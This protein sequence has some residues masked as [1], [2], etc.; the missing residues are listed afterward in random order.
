MGSGFYEI[1]FTEKAIEHLRFWHKS[2][3]KSILAKI[4]QLVESIRE[5]PTTGISK[6]ELLK[7]ELVGKY[8][9]RIN[10]EHRIIYQID[11]SLVTIPS[12]KGHYES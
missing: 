8:S 9:Q 10:Q 1:E 2:G 6:P 3:Q 12:L 7:H 11:D 5:T 4:E